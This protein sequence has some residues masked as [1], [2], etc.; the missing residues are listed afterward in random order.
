[1]RVNRSAYVKFK[2]TPNEREKI[3]SI[4][5]L[6]NHKSTAD[7]LLSALVE[8]VEKHSSI[9]VSELKEDRRTNYGR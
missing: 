9:D 6:L 5:K 1:M 4:G 3:I 2:A 8:Y 7:L